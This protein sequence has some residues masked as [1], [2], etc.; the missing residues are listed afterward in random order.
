ME[1]NVPVLSAAGEEEWV[2]AR[3]DRRAGDTKVVRVEGSPFTNTVVR[4][5]TQ[6][7]ELVTS[8]PGQELREDTPPVGHVG[9][10]FPQGNA[11]VELRMKL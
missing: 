4:P 1:F 11:T 7:A 6:G 2:M 3:V 5:W 9:W 8:S 10:V